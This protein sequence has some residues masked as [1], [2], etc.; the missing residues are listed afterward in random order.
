MNRREL[1]AR[2]E[3]LALRY[4]EQ[5]GLKRL[6]SNFGCRFGEIDLIMLDRRELVF[7]EVRSRRS[8]IYGGALG[9]VSPAKQRRITRAAAVFL[10]SHRDYAALPCRFDV[11]G[12][13]NS[14]INPRV[15]WIRSAF[16]ASG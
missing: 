2:A 16:L 7:V 13:T 14:A 6:A 1:G 3:G 10:Q 12:L 9:S 11:V 4:L 15:E 5:R 8:A